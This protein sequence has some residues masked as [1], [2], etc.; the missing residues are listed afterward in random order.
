MGQ[1]LYQ[2][3]D[4][5]GIPDRASYWMSGWELMRRLNFEED[6]LNNRV[7]G[8]TVRH[9]SFSKQL[10]GDPAVPEAWRSALKILNGTFEGPSIKQT[11]SD[12]T[13]DVFLRPF[14]IALGSPEFQ[15]K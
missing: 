2:F 5:T 10:P 1:F 4:P 14:V 6:L 9:E 15:H 7:L 13:P 11:S 12:L 3:Q 8:T